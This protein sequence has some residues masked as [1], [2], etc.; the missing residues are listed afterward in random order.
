[1]IKLSIC[2]ATYN[3]SEFLYETLLCL[4]KQLQ[5]GV[6]IIIVDGN[7]TDRTFEV[8]KIFTSQSNSIRYYKELI[9]SGVDADFDKAVLYAKGEYCWL[10]SDDDLL[11]KDAIEYILKLISSKY[12]LLVVNSNIYS[13]EMNILLLENILNIRN[14]IDFTDECEQAF[15]IIARYLSFIG[16]IIVKREFWLTRERHFYHGSEFAHIGVLFQYPPVSSIKIIAKPLIMIRYGNSQWATRGFEVWIKQWPA[17]INTLTSFSTNSRSYILNNNTFGLLKFCCLYRAMGIYN[18]DKYYN[19]FDIF[20]NLLK[21]IVLKIIANLPSKFLNFMISIILIK[22]SKLTI[23]RLLNSI[24][25][26]KMCIFIAR[27]RG[28]L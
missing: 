13:K 2:I 26:T 7:S 22:G 14:D 18:I 20:S 16:A 6:E 15:R 4:S 10:F 27:L 28:L 3:R 25:S 21:K 8:S 24:S 9:N 11:I 17:I 1:M 19:N 5:D 23:Y 12:N